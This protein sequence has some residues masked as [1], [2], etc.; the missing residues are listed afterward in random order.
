MYA[1]AEFNAPLPRVMSHDDVSAL[2]VPKSQ[3][4][5]AGSYREP[6]TLSASLALLAPFAQPHLATPSPSMS[7]NKSKVPPKQVQTQAEHALARYPELRIL[8]YEDC[9]KVAAVF[10]LRC[11]VHC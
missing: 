9:C 1:I 5:V 11:S 8:G 6:A 3:L 7:N 4:H 10:E 2:P